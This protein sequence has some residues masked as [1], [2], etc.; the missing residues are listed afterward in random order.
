[1]IKDSSIIKVIINKSINLLHS[2][3]WALNNN[4]VRLSIWRKIQGKFSIIRFK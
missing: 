1:M 4:V 3:F 2:K